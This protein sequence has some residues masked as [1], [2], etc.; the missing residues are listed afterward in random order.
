MHSGLHCISLFFP[1]SCLIL[2]LNQSIVCI[3]FQ[4]FMSRTNKSIL[5]S[6]DLPPSQCSSLAYCLSCLLSYFI[7]RLQHL[8]RPFLVLSWSLLWFCGSP[9]PC[10]CA[11][12][13]G[14]Y[15]VITHLPLF[16]MFLVCVF[17]NI[18]FPHSVLRE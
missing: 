5:R 1:R 11:G 13:E 9:S 18:Y 6:F 17:L 4:V 7:T 2:S 10:T 3:A 14:F 12:L 16:E 15:D 8:F